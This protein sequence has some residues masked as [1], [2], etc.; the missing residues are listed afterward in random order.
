MLDVVNW[1]TISKDKPEAWLYFYEDFLEVYDNDLRKL[2]GSYYTPPEVVAAMV[3]T[4]RRGAARTA[5][6]APGGACLRRRDARR[7]GYG[8]R[9]L[10]AR[11]DAP[12]RDDIEDG[13]GT[14]RSARRG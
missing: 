6:F 7:S 2:T 3:E 1:H 11:R 9:H 10:P 12:D 8:H 4:G 13:P 14:G 5:V